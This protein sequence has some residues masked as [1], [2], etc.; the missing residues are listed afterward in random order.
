MFKLDMDI[1][2]L[3]EPADIHPAE[4][5]MKE[6]P[7][8]ERWEERLEGLG[9]TSGAKWKEHL[10]KIVWSSICGVG[11]GLAVVIFVLGEI[12]EVL[13]DLLWAFGIAESDKFSIVLIS[14]AIC[15]MIGAMIGAVKAVIEIR[16]EKN[17]EKASD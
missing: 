12:G 14:A 16:K 11:A 7:E 2:C 3:G 10:D 5:T 15:G 13:G 1:L 8:K 4:N 9:I 6:P 17:E